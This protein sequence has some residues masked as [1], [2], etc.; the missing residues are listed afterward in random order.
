MNREIAW[1]TLAASGLCA[2]V[3]SALLKRATSLGL[4]IL[5]TRVMLVAA[6]A[7]A[8][9]GVGFVLYGYSLRFLPVGV[10]YVCMVAI[11]ALLLF[12]YSFANG[13]TVHVHQWIGAAVVMVGVYLIAGARI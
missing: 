4:P 8:V 11:A 5:S 13:D 6:A 10:A 9:Y 12:V 3:A 7:I 2:A 1:L